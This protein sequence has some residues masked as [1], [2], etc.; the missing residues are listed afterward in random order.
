MFPFHFFPSQK[1]IENKFAQ[2]DSC[3]YNGKTTVRISIYNET[4]ERM[5]KMIET[6]FKELK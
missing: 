3:A 4:P 2:S 6:G 5:E 1:I